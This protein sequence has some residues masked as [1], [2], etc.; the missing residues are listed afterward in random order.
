MIHVASHTETDG[1]AWNELFASES[2]RGVVLVFVS[3]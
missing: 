3:L 1:E 2:S